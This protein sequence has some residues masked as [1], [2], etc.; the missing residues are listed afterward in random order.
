MY[1]PYLITVGSSPNQQGST[2]VLPTL[3]GGRDAF[4]AEGL[5]N[6]GVTPVTNIDTGV[7]INEIV[8][9]A[10]ILAGFLSIV[11]MLW[12]G[13]QYIVSGG[14]EDKVKKATCI[15]RSGCDHIIGQCY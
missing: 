4:T 2:N 3:P 10:I 13:I 5:Q 8:A 7:L 11:F 9:Y 15:N 12:G 6:L 14:K 1:L